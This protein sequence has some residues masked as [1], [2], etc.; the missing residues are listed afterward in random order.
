MSVPCSGTHSTNQ[1]PPGEI[2]SLL[3]AAIFFMLFMC[4]DCGKQGLFAVTFFISHLCCP[5]SFLPHLVLALLC[6]IAGTPSNPKH[7]RNKEKGR[8]KEGKKEN[9]FFKETDTKKYQREIVLWIPVNV[10]FYEHMVYI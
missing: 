6:A 7:K 2:M 3:N 4:H 5:V 9:I 1:Q 10:T 8:E